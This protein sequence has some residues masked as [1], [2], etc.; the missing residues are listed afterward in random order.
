MR[1]KKVL[2]V[3]STT[4]L[5]GMAFPFCGMRASAESDPAK[6]ATVA[7]SAYVLRVEGDRAI[8]DTEFPG[9]TGKAVEFFEKQPSLKHPVTGAPVELE[10]VVTQAELVT[11][12]EGYSIAKLEPEDAPKVKPGMI[13]RR[14]K[15]QAEIR[16]EQNLLGV[17]GMSGSMASFPH[18]EPA[19]SITSSFRGN[20][21]SAD[22]NY[23]IGRLFYERVVNI[24]NEQ[25]VLET[26]SFGFQ[27][28]KGKVQDSMKVSPRFLQGSG[29][30]R[31]RFAQL[32]AFTGGL[33]TGIGDTEGS[34]YGM[35]LGVSLGLPRD[36][37]FDLSAERVADFALLMDAS[38]KFR[39][40]PK[41]KG[42][43]GFGTDKFPNRSYPYRV[44]TAY[45]DA[46]GEFSFGKSVAVL[47]K[48]GVT[49]ATVSKLGPTGT[50]EL[51]ISP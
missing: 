45:F 31:V 51:R 44:T 12:G 33:S 9:L 32:L 50:I 18:L 48:A 25:I 49:G 10:L 46:G 34:N 30:A 4:G 20:W 17:S 42:V 36:F 16:T 14:K 5:C 35:Y 23:G 2:A 40:F 27:G 29:R 8:I 13:V 19:H 47:A 15:T 41:V 39:L 28:G 37:V 26:V 21:S 3:L 7:R 6:G 24:A 1:F 38:L 43:L 22:S 11:T